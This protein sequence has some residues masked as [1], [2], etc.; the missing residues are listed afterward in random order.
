MSQHESPSRKSFQLSLR[1][2][3]LALGLAMA[4]LGLSLLQFFQLP[5]LLLLLLVLFFSAAT[6]LGRSIGLYFFV[7]I[8]FF[9]KFS[10]VGYY[11][12]NAL[13]ELTYSDFLFPI[14]L[15]AFMGIC[16][17]FFEI[18]KFRQAFY[19][20]TPQDELGAESQSLVRLKIRF[21][22]L[23]GG[24]W[25]LIP[26]AVT[27]AL[28]ILTLIPF[29]TS[30]IREYWITPRGARTIFL[31]SFLFFLWFVCRGIFGV[32]QRWTMS[33]E[34]AKIQMRSLFAHEFW[35]EQSAI[36]KRAAKVRSKIR[37]R[38]G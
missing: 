26:A 23:L 28:L 11:Q 27:S 6:W 21:P 16:F 7:I 37:K 3:N 8:I 35:R 24:R 31:G 19:P 12:R 9:I 10:R 32:I 22:S 34:Q 29:D 1:D 38:Q 15:L 4:L 33:S 18:R 14:L 2:S 17:R 5:L 13:R 20:K 30:T 25:V 36:E